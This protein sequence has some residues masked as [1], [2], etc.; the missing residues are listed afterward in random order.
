MARRRQIGLRLAVASVVAV[1]LAVAWGTVAMWAGVFVVQFQYRAQVYE[2]ILV[3]ADGTPVVQTQQLRNYRWSDQTYRTLDGKVVEVGT[4]D[5]LP[6]TSFASRDKPPGLFEYNFH[7]AERLAGVGG[8]QPTSALWFAVRDDQPLGRVYLVGY[9]SKSNALV[10]YIA[11]N[12]FGRALPPRDQWFDI[13][14]APL[15]W[16]NGAIASTSQIAPAA[17]SYSYSYVT[18]ESQLPPWLLYVIDGEAVIEVDVRSH[19]VR[20]VLKATNIGQVTMGYEQ[21]PSAARSTAAEQKGREEPATKTRQPDFI[22]RVAVRTDDRVIVI[23]PAKGD[24]R[25]YLLNGSFRDT[26]FS[27]YLLASGEL[28][29]EWQ[30][31]GAP[32]GETNLAWLRTDGSIARQE[33]LSLAAVPQP[34]EK[35]GMWLAVPVA[36]VA[37]G[38]LA[39]V[40]VIAPLGMIQSNEVATY[41]EGLRKV[42]DVAGLPLVAVVAISILLALQ[43]MRLQRRYHRGDTGAWATFVFLLG[44]P[45]FVAY[46]VENRRAKMEECGACHEVVPRDREACASCHAEFAP[47]PRV[48]TEVFA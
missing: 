19:S 21:P 8:G 7:W 12:G 34:S 17:K 33:K 47:P 22:P 15:A 4:S 11:R 6:A 40:S 3:R 37:A 30:E 1:G 5:Q 31:K 9:D 35:L 32:P 45:G 44:V 25:E 42:F 24:R 27:G 28:L 13:G 46:L 23:D 16:G 38:W 43:T 10:G 41:G 20:T 2:N 36:P 18:G 48:G 14:R 29:V 26:Y 39:G